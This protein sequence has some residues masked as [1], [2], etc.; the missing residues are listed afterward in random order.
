[1]TQ[2]LCLARMPLKSVA[3]FKSYLTYLHIFLYTIIHLNIA[4][5]K[6]CNNTVFV[7]YNNNIKI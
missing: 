2:Q 7:Y 3:M 5:Y 1:M 6:K 4:S